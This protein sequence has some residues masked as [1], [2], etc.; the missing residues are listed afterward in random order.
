MTRTGAIGWHCSGIEFRVRSKGFPTLAEL[1]YLTA[2]PTALATRM[3][4][5]APRPEFRE[6]APWPPGTRFLDGRAERILQGQMPPRPDARPYIGSAAGLTAD[7]ALA[8]L[9]AGD[10]TAERLAKDAARQRR[11]RARRASG[12]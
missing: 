3:P 7:S 2:P 12:L 11:K 10:L 1:R 8:E 5:D 6:L 4:L 9:S